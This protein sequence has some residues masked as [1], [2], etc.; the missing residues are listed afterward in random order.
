[1]ERNQHEVQLE[2][3]F[4]TRRD[5]LSRCG[6]GVG[7][8]GLASLMDAAG[9]LTPTAR[10]DS[11]LLS[12]LAPRLP[13]F[14]GKAKQVIHLFMAGGPSHV[15]TFDPKP[16]LAK[17]AGKAIKDIDKTI[18]RA[19]AAFPSPFKFS[20]HGKS[21]IEISEVFPHLA[22]HVDEMTIIRSM[23][24]PIP[25]HEIGMLMM[26]TGESR[27]VRPSVGSWVTYGLGTENQNLPGFIVL[28]AQ[29]QP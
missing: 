29:G 26:N 18:T 28:S 10:A 2:D 9:L 27:F 22:E 14:P 12:P 6:M 16:A 17:Y 19:G 5:F 7:A 15:D 24:T 3:R 25:S 1:M 11:S 8:L 21:G 4:L 13:Q 23:H 20:P